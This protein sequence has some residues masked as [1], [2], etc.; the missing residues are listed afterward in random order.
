MDLYNNTITIKKNQTNRYFIINARN[1]KKIYTNESE[2]F[3]TYF[4]KKLDNTIQDNLNQKIIIILDIFNFTKQQ[5][6]MPFL[7]KFI[8]YFKQPIIKEKYKNCFK[9]IVV[10]N[11]NQGFKTLF[12][13]VKL[14][15]NKDLRRIIE[16]HNKIKRKDWNNIHKKYDYTMLTK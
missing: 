1:F 16:F 10:I 15:M 12:D 3:I 11:Y 9:K 6:T 4:V 14:F 13:I 8:N 2:E 5:I 7:M